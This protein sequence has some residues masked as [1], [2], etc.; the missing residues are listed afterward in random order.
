MKGVLGRARARRRECGLGGGCQVCWAGPM[1]KLW[2]GS[3]IVSFSLLEVFVIDE[4]TNKK[5]SKEKKKVQFTSHSLNY[6][7]IFL[8][9]Q[10]L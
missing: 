6:K 1:A 4:P 10:L 8:P 5:E 7:T 9:R 3:C 2:A